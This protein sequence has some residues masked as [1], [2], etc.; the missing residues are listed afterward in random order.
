MKT[1]TLVIMGKSAKVGNFCVG[2]ID[3]DTNEWIRPISEDPQIEEAVPPQDLTCKDGAQVELLDV[4]RIN[5]S[6]RAAN[7]PIQPENFFYDSDYYWLKIGHMTLPEV[8]NVHGFDW[9]D[10]IFYNDDRAIP[11]DDVK[12]LPVRESLLLLPIGN[13]FVTVD[14]SQGYPKFFA[15]FEY[16][17]KPIEHFSIGD[18]AVRKQFEGRGAG[19]YFFKRNAVVVFSLTNPFKFNAK[20]YKM[21]AQ[22][23]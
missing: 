19:K 14:T 12:K 3:L 21:V 5:F 20:C 11:S 23:F 22:V 16:R 2:G 8:V 9:R 1:R 7:N 18:I 4:V 15:D 10:K 17:G 6:E 13:L